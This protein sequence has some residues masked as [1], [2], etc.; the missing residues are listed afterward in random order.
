MGQIQ[1]AFLQGLG[2][3]SQIAQMYRLTQPY[4]KG[5]KEKAAKEAAAKATQEAQVNYDY[6]KYKDKIIKGITE[7]QKAQWLK[8]NE[9]FE[10]ASAQE[11]RLRRD[12]LKNTVNTN[13]KVVKPGQDFSTY[14][15][16][17][18]WT[19]EQGIRDE[20]L[21]NQYYPKKDNEVAAAQARTSLKSTPYYLNL[22]QAAEESESAE[23]RKKNMKNIAKG[24]TV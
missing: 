19:F 11:R 2:V 9:R 10:T 6:A 17:G 18:G 16:E 7:E 1:N 23:S 14:K 24:G 8:E 5:Q 15:G 13:L 21:M 22:Q 20:Y 3:V 4:I 12:F